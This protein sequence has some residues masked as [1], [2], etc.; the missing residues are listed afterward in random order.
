MLD[1][2]VADDVG[3]AVVK[4]FEIMTRLDSERATE[5]DAHRRQAQFDVMV[6]EQHGQAAA[7]LE[8]ALEGVEY[9]LIPFDNRLELCNRSV[10]VC[11]E[12][13]P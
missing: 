3:L 5:R 10:R 13:R 4:E 2:C 6:S 12:R 8:K 11:R 9:P 1:Q 7:L